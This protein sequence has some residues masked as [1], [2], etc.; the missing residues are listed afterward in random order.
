MNS[1]LEILTIVFSFSFLFSVLRGATPLVFAAMG[2]LLSERSG[3][4]QIGLEGFMVFGALFASVGALATGSPWLGFILGSFVAGIAA[5]LFA[6]FVLEIKTDQVVT[7]TAFNILALGIAPFVTKLLYGSTG[8]APSLEI[9]QRFSFEP[10]LIAA[11]IGF[12]IWYFYQLTKLGL[13]L[14]FSGE[15]PQAL[16][17]AGYSLTKVRW[18][19]LFL[20]GSLAG[21]GGASLSLLLASSYSPNMTAGRGFIA[22][23][24][25]IFGKWKPHLTI[26]ACLFFALV[27][28]LQ[29]SLQGPLSNNG[30]PL[31]L[32]QAFPYVVTII[33]L[34]G[35]FGKSK[36]PQA[37]GKGF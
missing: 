30:I 27:D 2:G 18:I 5:L 21:M 19:S 4:V 24:A 11:L 3:I 29:I 35:F 1:F 23:A 13:I 34:A 22:L 8:S 31:Q 15:A 12:L 25:L 26:Y 10:I 28:S 17:V 7:G 16:S 14:R 37:L 6:F 36:A 9:S 33:A 32:I 20:T